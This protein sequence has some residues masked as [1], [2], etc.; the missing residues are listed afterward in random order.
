M[1]KPLQI[2]LLLA[3]YALLGALS[4]L[5]FDGTGDVGDSVMHYLY[6]KSAVQHPHLYF[7]HWAKPLYVLLASPF[8]QF[9]FNGIKVFN[10]LNTGLTLFL[11]YKCAERLQLHNPLLAALLA[12]FSPLYYV[13]TL[14]GLTEP[15]FALFVALALYFSL[16]HRP[17]SAALVISFLPYVRSEGLIIAG[18]YLLYY[19]VIKKWKA[20]P[21]LLT[22]SVLYGIAGY[23]VHGN[24]FW[25]FAKIPYATLNSVYGSGNLF[26]FVSELYFVVGAPVYILFCVGFVLL[27]LRFFRT[28]FSPEMRWIVFLGFSAFFIAHSA[29]WY[30]GIFNSMGL[31][32]VLLGLMPYTALIALYGFNAITTKTKSYNPVAAHLISGGFIFYALI[33]PLLPN[34]ASVNVERDL[35]LTNEQKLAQDLCKHIQKENLV[36]PIV[37]NHFYLS[38]VLGIDH[39]DHSRRVELDSNWIAALK[40]GTLLVWENLYALKMSGS[41]KNSLEQNPQLIKRF[42]CSGKVQDFEMVWALFEKK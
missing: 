16:Q 25:V 30:L 42:E 22:G 3:F 28:P 2:Y 21:F 9:G 31:K 7:D 13:L 23:F 8:A 36:Y 33:F 41:T 5:F 24:F 20:I 19:C 12:M 39:F 14:S 38:E 6:A 1:F 34:P 29:F 11:I 18:V 27:A 4:I 15:L 32:R 35:M 40:P 10:L 26:H 17:L 37:Y